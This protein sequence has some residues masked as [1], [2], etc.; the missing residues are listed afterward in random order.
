MDIWTNK[1]GAHTFQEK[2]GSLFKAS[3]SSLPKAFFFKT[4]F[5]LRKRTIIL[6]LHNPV[7]WNLHLIMLLHAVKMYYH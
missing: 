7:L 6:T 4:S 1:Q 2:K 3:L 5:Y